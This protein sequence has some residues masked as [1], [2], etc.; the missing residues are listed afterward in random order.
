ML[1]ITA[2]F[3]TSCRSKGPEVIDNDDL[4]QIYAEM[5]LTDQWIITNPS[6]RTIADTSLVYEPILQKYGY[7]SDDYRHSI[8]AYLSNPK[9]FAEIF[10]E[11]VE[12]LDSRLKALNLEKEDIKKIEDAKRYVNSMSKY[13]NIDPSLMFADRMTETGRITTDDSLDVRWDTVYFCFR[14]LRVPRFEASDS[15]Q[16]QDSLAALDSLAVLDSLT[17]LDSLPV[18]DTARKWNNDKVGRIKRFQ[19]KDIHRISDELIKS[20]REWE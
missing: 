10:E 15:L 7:T 20:E 3:L 18:L 2:T 5:L 6:L 19:N 13:F 12:I 14:M 4:A 17:V 1:V 8:D 11:T 9:K 16:V